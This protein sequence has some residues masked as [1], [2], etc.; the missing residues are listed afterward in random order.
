MLH[1][2]IVLMHPPSDLPQETSFTRKA[3]AVFVCG[4]NVMIGFQK[5]NIISSTGE[6]VSL[7]HLFTPVCALVPPFR[8]PPQIKIGTVALIAG[9]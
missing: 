9:V 8:I 4:R 5:T 6:Q 3:K 1:V 2:A 7:G